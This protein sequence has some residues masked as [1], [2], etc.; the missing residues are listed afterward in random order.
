[1][2]CTSNPPSAAEMSHS[3][4]FTIIQR[5]P[6]SQTSR[7]NLPPHSWNDPHCTHTSQTW[8]YA[9]A[10]LLLRFR[11]ELPEHCSAIINH[12]PAAYH[13]VEFTG[14]QRF[15]MY[16]TSSRGVWTPNK[17]SVVPPTCITSPSTVWSWC[18]AL[19]KL[20]KHANAVFPWQRT[21]K[22]EWVTDCH[23]SYEGGWQRVR[24]FPCCCP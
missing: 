15:S 22:L 5:V 16:A 12:I 21:L 2:R 18:T 19:L 23:K 9:Q 13:V 10:T 24:R 7:K 11:I 8:A 17:L 1:M 4:V 3:H 20:S 6:S 14:L